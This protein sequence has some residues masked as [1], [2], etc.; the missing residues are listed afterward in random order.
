MA[1]SFL[2]IFKRD[3]PLINSLR[4][5]KVDKDRKWVYNLIAWSIENK[6]KDYTTF[7]RR[8]QSSVH[9]AK[10]KYEDYWVNPKNI[11]Q[12]NLAME[13]LKKNKYFID[14]V[15]QTSKMYNKRTKVLNRLYHKGKLS[16]KSMKII[17]R[18]LE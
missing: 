4:S 12:H 18:E 5:A 2:D 11:R 15:R 16:K 17:E 13:R 10:G 8:I 7:Q 3:T 9:Y 1:N 6:N 14:K